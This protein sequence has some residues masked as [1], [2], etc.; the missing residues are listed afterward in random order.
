MRISVVL[1]TYNRAQSLIKALESVAA[2]SLP[3]STEWE[4]VVVDNNSSDQTRE[5]VF[6]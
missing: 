1:C 6:L 4:V 3:E 2:Q 5:V